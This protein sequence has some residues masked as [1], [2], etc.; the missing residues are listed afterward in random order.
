MKRIMLVM[1]F[2][3]VHFAVLGQTVTGPIK[4]TDVNGIVFWQTGQTLKQA[5]DLLPST[6]GIV[7]LPVATIS[8]GYSIAAPLTKSNVTLMGSGMPTFLSDRLSSGTII[9][10]P[11]TVNADYFSAYNLGVDMGPYVTN[12]FYSGVV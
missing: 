5:V 10:G 1:T 3:F 9:Q 2:L 8:S 11:L 7:M 6:G 12:T 4:P